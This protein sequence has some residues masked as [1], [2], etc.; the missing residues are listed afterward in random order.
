MGS[1]CSVDTL[2]PCVAPCFAFEKFETILKLLLIFSIFSFSNFILKALKQMCYNWFSLL[3][4]VS[5]FGRNSY[6]NVKTFPI[7]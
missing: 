3:K 5:T 6:A 4:I 2:V 7:I 1:L